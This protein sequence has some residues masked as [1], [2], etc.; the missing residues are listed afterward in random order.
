[1]TVRRLKEV[2]NLYSPDVVFLAETKNK[3][4]KIEKIA[5]IVRLEQ[6]VTMDPWGLSGGECLLAK[7]GVKLEVLEVARGTID[8]RVTDRIGRCTKMVGI[9]ASTNLS[10]RRG[11]WR[12]L[13][14][15]LVSTQEPCVIAGDFNCIFTN[16]EK[17]G[18]VDKE[19]WELIDFQRFM[20]D[21]DLIDIGFVGYPFTWNNKRGGRANI[22]MRLDRALVNPRW[23]SDF[24]LGSLHHLPSGGSDHCPILLRFGAARARGP[25]RFIFYSRWTSKEAC[26]NIVRT[27]WAKKFVGSRWYCILQ[28]LRL[29]RR[30]LR[31]WRA[32][33]QLNSQSR[34]KELQDQ[35]VQEFEKDEFDASQYRRIEEGMRQATGAEE[36][37]WRNKSRVSWLRLGDKNTAFFHAKTVQR[38]AENRIHGLEDKDGAWKVQSGEVEAIIS[39]YFKHMFSLSNPVMLEEVLREVK[40]RVSMDMNDRLLKP[41]CMEEVRVAVFQ[42]EPSASPGPDGMTA[43]EGLS[44][45]L[46]K[47]EEDKSF[48]GVKICRNSPSVSHL[49]FADDTLLFVEA[50]PYVRVADFAKEFKV[51]HFIDANRSKRKEDLVRETFTSED[52]NLILGIP[53]S[54]FGRKDR[55]VWHFTG[56]GVY[57]VKSGYEAALNLRRSGQLGRTNV[58]EGSSRS[59]RKEL[60]KSVWALPCQEKVKHFIWKCFHDIVPFYDVL[61]RRKI[62]DHVLC[63]L[64]SSIPSMSHL[65]LPFSFKTA[66]GIAFGSF[67]R[68][69]VPHLHL[70]S[71]PLQNLAFDHVLYIYYQLICHCYATAPMNSTPV[72]VAI[73]GNLYFYG[74]VTSR[75]ARIYLF[76]LLSRFLASFNSVILQFLFM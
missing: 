18:R 16:E 76:M 12:H 29:C 56:N 17:S 11:L 30:K 61:A 60:W 55:A 67:D 41:V 62:T 53:I 14:H 5:K 32:N 63:P 6:V 39:D 1:M 22:R 19:E 50:S 35:L 66:V 59:G 28:K 27:C 31:H 25:S 58:G 74:H 44:A 38:R 72:I 4:E 34:M 45:L 21:N 7:A 8:A 33:Q 51:S 37:Y 64:C 43:G 47:G 65:L 13:A 69:P 20:D 68:D 54:R 2:C 49:F 46:R 75:L 3:Q 57:T 24:P 15:I 10:E 26:G 42:M 70:D 9:Y 73:V 40:P 71:V 23:R 36:E 48:K 52:A